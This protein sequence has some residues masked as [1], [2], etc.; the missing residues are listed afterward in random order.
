MR[1]GTARGRAGLFERRDDPV[2]QLS[3]RARR[4]GRLRQLSGQYRASTS[5]AGDVW[6]NITAGTNTF[7]RWATSGGQV[8]VHEIGHAIGLAHPGDYNAGDDEDP[9]TYADAAVYYEDSRQYTVMSYFP[10]PTPGPPTAAATPPRPCWTTSAPPRWSTAPTCR[11]RTGDT[12][13]GFNSNAGRD[14]FDG[15]QQLHAAGLRGVG[16]R[17]TGT[18]S[19]SPATPRTPR[20][21]CAKASSPTSAGLSGNV[22][23]AQ[24]AVIENAIGGLGGHTL[25]GNALN[26][27]IQGV[28][29]AN[30]RIRR[31]GAD[32]IAREGAGTSY[33]RGD[34][35]N[36]YIIGGS[37]FDDI[38]GNMGNDT[39]SAAPA[40]TGWSAART[41][42]RLFG[43]AG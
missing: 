7:P 38:Q 20:S 43:K 11:T 10:R 22:A 31:G 30:Q 21:T 15:G 16:R 26:N 4:L 32:T 40:R 42:D 39:A 27:A 1:V 5:S 41:N 6:V 13:Y 12:V 19:T 35:G 37:V 2:R 14:W 24:G 36:D 34:E 18:P 33:L 9:I 8:L 29:G 3:A 17:R 23:V 28:A 25:N